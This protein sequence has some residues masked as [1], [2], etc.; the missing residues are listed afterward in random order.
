VD[1]LTSTSFDRNA[2]Y[3]YLVRLR[4]EHFG[5]DPIDILDVGDP[6]GILQALL[7]DDNTFSLDLFKEGEPLA[8]RHFHIIGSG[9][10]LPFPDGAFDIVA[11]H[12]VLEHLPSGT[13]AQFAVELRRVSRGPVVLVAP[14]ADERT[15]RCE[16]IANTYY[17]T[18]TGHTLQPLDEHAE[19]DGLPTLD[20]LVGWAIT[21]GIP[22]V[23][24]SGGWLGHWLT[25]MMLKAHFAATGDIVSDR[26]FDTAFNLSLRDRD[27]L[28]PHYRRAVILDPPRDIAPSRIIES[29]AETIS[30]ETTELTEIAWKVAGTLF[31]GE[32]P[33]LP[34][35]RFRSLWDRTATPGSITDELSVSIRRLMDELDQ[36][37]TYG[38]VF[39]DET[40]PSL[41]VIVAVLDRDVQEVPGC[42]KRLLTL[43]EAYGQAELVVSLQDSEK[44]R[45]ESVGSPKLRWVDEPAD[46]HILRLNAAVATCTAECLVFIDPRL[47]VPPDFL[48]ALVRSYKPTQGVTCVAPRGTNGS[49]AVL[50]VS[51]VGEEA[52]FAPKQA[53]L[54]ARSSYVGLA[55]FDGSLLGLF[56]D[57]DFGWRLRIIGQKVARSFTDASRSL[58]SV[59]EE[60]RWHDPR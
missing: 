59:P 14:F 8:E 58:Q 23:V 13:H 19:G 26:S 11:T 21:S 25:M 50:G 4:S 36:R 34:G 31:P 38:T 17:A 40:A 37:Q 1:G 43:V 15:A 35:S 16:E 27:E 24:Y 53:V 39:A 5:E 33:D 47:D 2:R 49:S 30:M 42:V 6:Y 54:V 12:D 44:V 9:F 55:G 41:A 28:A 46:D 56:D 45:L 52:F 18:R 3:Q 57:L 60:L 51:D 29:S 20:T 22:A 48:H 10:Q 32:T 7:P